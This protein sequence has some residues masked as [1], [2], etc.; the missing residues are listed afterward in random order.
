MIGKVNYLCI[1]LNKTQETEL[2]LFM[3]RS[4]RVACRKAY[5]FAKNIN[6]LNY[7]LCMPLVEDSKIAFLSAAAKLFFNLF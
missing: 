6:V 5:R 4:D 3:S 2:T 7:C 1:V